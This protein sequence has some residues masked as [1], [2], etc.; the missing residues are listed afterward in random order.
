MKLDWST[1]PLSEGLACYR[2]AQFF[3][4]HEHWELVWLTLNEPEKSFLQAIVQIT[5]A[6]HHLRKG[7]GIGA[8]SLL[9]RSLSRLSHCA[10]EFGGVKVEP[11]RRELTSALQAIGRGTQP[12]EIVAPEIEPTDARPE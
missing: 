6:M 5:A 2:R 9:R 1:A 8:A 10:P 7:N 3:E 11:L 12:G 4:A